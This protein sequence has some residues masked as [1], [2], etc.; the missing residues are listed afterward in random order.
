MEIGFNSR[1]LSEMLNNL[2]SK[3]IV[4]KLSEPNRAGII[5][6]LDHIEEGE[7]TAML[8]MPVVLKPNA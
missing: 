6:P 5:S 2:N 1:F 3:E 7:K 4:M 8:V